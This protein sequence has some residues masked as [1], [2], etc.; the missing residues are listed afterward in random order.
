[1]LFKKIMITLKCY[2]K[3]HKHVKMLFKISDLRKIDIHF[4][5]IHVKV[6]FKITRSR[7]NGIQ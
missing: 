2:S 6:L 1:M 4:E 3:F 5:P 7:K